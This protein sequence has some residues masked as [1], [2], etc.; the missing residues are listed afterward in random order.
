MVFVRSF[1]GRHESAVVG[2]ISC[3]NVTSRKIPSLARVQVAVL[4]FHPP[5]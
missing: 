5:R 3:G 1:T 4:G 2:E